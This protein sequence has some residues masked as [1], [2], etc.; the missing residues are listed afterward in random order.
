TANTEIIAPIDVVKMPPWWSA[1]IAQEE[2]TDAPDIY[3]Y[4]NLRIFEN[5]ADKGIAYAFPTISH[6]NFWGVINHD[7]DEGLIRVADNTISQGLKIWT[8]GYASANIPIEVY[9]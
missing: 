6:S 7:N 5:W 2:L 1:T 9:S 3:I 8:W 4:D